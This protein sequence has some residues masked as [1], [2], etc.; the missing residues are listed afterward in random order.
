[1]TAIPLPSSGGTAPAGPA[2]RGRAPAG[3]RARTRVKQDPVTISILVVVLVALIALVLLPLTRVLGEAVSGKGMAVLRNIVSSAA[4]R[5]TVLNTLVLG[6]V[7]GAV[8]TLVGFLLAYVQIGRA[9]V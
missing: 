6:V 5:T 8:G 9:H 7:V 2:T 3:R 4:N 1:M